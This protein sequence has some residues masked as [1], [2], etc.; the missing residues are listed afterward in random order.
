[1]GAFIIFRG[2]TRD[3]KKKYSSSIE[4]FNNKNLKLNNEFIGDDFHVLLYGKQKVKVVNYH[5]FA[6]GDFAL[7]TGSFVYKNKIENQALELIHNDFD[8]SGDC[9]NAIRGNYALIIFKKG[10]LYIF[11]DSAGG[12]NIYTNAEQSIITS[13]LIALTKCQDKIEISPQEF[14]EYVSMGSCFGNKTVFKGL[15]KLDNCLIYTVSPQ[16]SNTCKKEIDV[17]DFVKKSKGK[18]KKQVEGIAKELENYFDELKDSFNNNIS[19]PITGGFDSRLVYA[20]VRKSGLVPDKAFVIKKDYQADIEIST[21]ICK[22]NNIEL[23]VLSTDFPN[24]KDDKSYGILKD[25]F[26][27]YDGLGIGGVFQYFSG[28]DIWKQINYKKAILD[29]T[30]GEIYRNMHRIPDSKVNLKSYIER[31]YLKKEIDFFTSKYNHDTFISEMQNKIRS[32]IDTDT[33]NV[34]RIDVEKIFPKFYLKGWFGSVISN[35]NQ[36]GYFFSPFFDELILQQSFYI[37]VK[38]KNNG[39]FEADLIKFLD[40]DLAKIRSNYGF[41]F[42]DKQPFKSTLI[43]W[44]K[45]H[46]PLNFKKIV[47]KIVRT[48]KNKDNRPF[49]VENK[50]VQESLQISDYVKGMLDVKQLAVEEYIN[51]DQVSDPAV[52]SRALSVELLLK[53]KF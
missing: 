33:N 44:F 53:D 22:S 30:G 17:S 23:D 9:V 26:Y 47:K 20:A 2:E 41:N 35:A 31:V 13:S 46:T 29:G 43:E 32:E 49:Y 3:I 15:S 1:M 52:V 5:K 24:F 39:G 40:P 38:Y 42:Y 10:K 28:L 4:V 27:S 25:Q 19:V 37:P 7:G 36:F 34:S 21:L 8:I 18:K 12:Y 16:L 6:N 14:Y 51:F 50:Y 45:I 48:K 11:N